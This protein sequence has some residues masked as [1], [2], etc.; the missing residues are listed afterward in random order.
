MLDLAEGRLLR[1]EGLALGVELLGVEGRACVGL[2]GV[3][4][5]V[6]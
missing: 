5:R 1:V 6:V 3:E 4:G 2:F